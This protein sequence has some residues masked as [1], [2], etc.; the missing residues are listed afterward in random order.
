MDMGT[1]VAPF[2]IVTSPDKE[3]Y[4]SIAENTQRRSV[5]QFINWF[6]ESE[7]FVIEKKR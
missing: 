7:Y 6:L 2:D 4:A 3:F 1:L 5:K